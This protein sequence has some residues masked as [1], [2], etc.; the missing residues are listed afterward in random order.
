MLDTLNS[1]GIEGGDASSDFIFA[2]AAGSGPSFQGTGSVAQR[3]LQSGGNFNALRTNAVLLRDEWKA[4]DTTIVDITRENLVAVAEV[5]NRGLVYALPNALGS[6]TLEWQEVLDDLVDAEVSMS[7]LVES[8]K[9]RLS[10]GTRSMPI[11]IIH[12]EFFYNLRFLEAA[13]RN[14]RAVDTEHAA[15]ATRKVAEKVEGILFNGLAIAQSQG[16]IYGLLNHP[17]RNTGAGLNFA[18]ATGE[19]IVTQVIA[20]LGVMG[21][22]YMNGPFVLFIPLG[23]EAHL[24]DDYKAGS[25]RT[26]FERLMAIPKLGKIVATPKLTGT[27]VLLV[28]MTSDV[29]QMIDGMQ[30]TMVEWETR[31]GFEF[32]FKIVAIMLPRIRSS[33]NKVSGIVHYA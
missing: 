14:G 3:L 23:A 30:P 26:I 16:I 32:N 9:D 5:M 31:G 17:D 29:V 15:I 12:K 24:G 27:N 11:P 22:K 28:Q 7:G 8:T 19:Q 20:M 10:F 1:G 2:N 4:F 25:D 18:T 21:T 6:L 13:R 33:G